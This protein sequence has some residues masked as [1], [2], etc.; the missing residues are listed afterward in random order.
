MN[1]FLRI[2]GILVVVVAYGYYTRHV[3]VQESKLEILDA[4]Q[5]LQPSSDVSTTHSRMLVRHQ[6]RM[7]WHMAGWLLIAVASAGVLLEDA[8]KLIRRGSIISGL[9]LLLGLGGRSNQS[10]WK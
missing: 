10:S 1:V 6:E 8:S 7:F 2:I 4:L 9:I 5:Q 3:A